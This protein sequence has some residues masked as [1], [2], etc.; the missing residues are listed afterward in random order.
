MALGFYGED[1]ADQPG[2]VIARGLQTDNAAALSVVPLEQ[3]PVPEPAA[4]ALLAV[5]VIVVV[6]GRG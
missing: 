4:W 1:G 3:V 2:W 6:V 5:P